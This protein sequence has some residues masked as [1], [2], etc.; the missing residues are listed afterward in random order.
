[1]ERITHNP[2]SDECPDYGSAAFAPVRAALRA[3]NQI[4]EEAAKQLLVDAWR[5]QIDSE[6][7]AWDRQVQE[8]NRLQAENDRV[9]LEDEER[10]RAQKEQASANHGHTTV[11]L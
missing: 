7:E 8:D 3:Q 1:M 5:Q 6:K 9:A 4:E 2:H 10:Q 11:T